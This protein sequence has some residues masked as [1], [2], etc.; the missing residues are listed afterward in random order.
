MWINREDLLNYPNI[1]RIQLSFIFYLTKLSAVISCYKGT[2]L[3]QAKGGQMARGVGG[4]GPANIMKH[5][6]GIRFPVMKLALIRHAS[7][8][9]GPDTNQVVKALREL[10]VPDDFLFA[11]TRHI[12]QLVCV[13]PMKLA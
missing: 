5:I 3:K 4:R 6:K 2:A 12:L 9:K 13:R 7:R 10:A 1:I 8:A 11:S